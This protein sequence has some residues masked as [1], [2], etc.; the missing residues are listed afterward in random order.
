VGV[1]GDAALGTF[2]LPPLPIVVS[3]VTKCCLKR[4]AQPFVLFIKHRK[5]ALIEPNAFA[6]VFTDIN[7]DAKILGYHF[8]AA[9]G[10]FHESSPL[11]CVVAQQELYEKFRLT[12]FMRNLS[13]YFDYAS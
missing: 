1:H 7:I 8:F 3:G 4:R 9:H 2:D 5:L 12:R 11:F 6:P 10:T 13:A